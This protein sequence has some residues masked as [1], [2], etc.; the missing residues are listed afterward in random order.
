MKLMRTAI[1]FLALLPGAQA[2]AYPPAIPGL[3]LPTAARLICVV[4]DGRRR[5]GA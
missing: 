2:F 3:V 5:G 1:S 4:L